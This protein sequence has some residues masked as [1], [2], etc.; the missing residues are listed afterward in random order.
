MRYKTTN[1]F[2]NLPQTALWQ[3]FL[4]NHFYQHS[5]NDSTDIII[6][7]SSLGI[8]S[9]VIDWSKQ[10]QSCYFIMV[11]VHEE[12]QAMLVPHHEE[13]I[14]HKGSTQRFMAVHW[15]QWYH[16]GL[17]IP[18]RLPDPINNNHWWRKPQSGRRKCGQ[19]YSNYYYAN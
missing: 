15:S 8:E 1:F 10:K 14:Y 12:K 9:H 2:T 18:R 19:M 4:I 16:S 13:N 3:T 11:V 7:Q 17:E 6:T 5:N